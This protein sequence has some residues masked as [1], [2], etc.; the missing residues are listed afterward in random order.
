MCDFNILWAWNQ[1]K[2]P[3]RGNVIYIACRRFVHFDN[4]HHFSIIIIIAYFHYILGDIK[5]FYIF[6]EYKKYLILKTTYSF[7]L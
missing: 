6:F 1:N 5:L 4:N 3:G 2:Y 7:K